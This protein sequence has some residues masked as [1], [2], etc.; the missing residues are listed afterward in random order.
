M[1]KLFQNLP[2]RP[3]TQTLTAYLTL[4]S[5]L[6]ISHPLF[7]QPLLTHPHP[8]TTI[9]SHLFPPNPNSHPNPTLPPTPTPTQSPTL[10]PLLHTA[11]KLLYSLVIDLTT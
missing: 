9:Y 7:T 11:I 10:L 2:P 4:L 3:Y 1:L 8:L 5:T 6:S